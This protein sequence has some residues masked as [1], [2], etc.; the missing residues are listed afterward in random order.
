MVTKQSMYFILM[1]TILFSGCGQKGNPEQDPSGSEENRS[2]VLYLSVEKFDDRLDLWVSDSVRTDI[3]AEGFEWSEGPLWLESEQLLLFSDVPTNT[4]FAWSETD[5][6]TTYLSPSGYTGAAERGGE[7]GSN[8]LLLDNDGGL[9]LC[10]HGDRRIA[11]MIA[12]LSD[13]RPVFETVAGKFDNMR[14]NSPNDLAID[15]SGT[16][17]FTDPP[18]GLEEFISDPT[19][20]TPYQGVYRIDPNGLVTLLTDS[21]TR[22]NGIALSPDE[23]V[24]YIGN[25]DGDKPWWLQYD[26]TAAGLEN[27]KILLDAG[28]VIDGA[29]GPDGMVVAEDGTLLSS[30]HGGIWIIHPDG[31]LLGRILIPQAVSNTTMDPSEKYLFV[32][33]YHQVLRLHLGVPD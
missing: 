31:T 5:G 12:T 33:A 13:P 28:R 20:E 2:N 21:I 9:L 32:T 23:S 29:R 8:G 6:L 22:P 30:G 17:Y 25:S 18:Y 10:Q 3:L 7:M 14:F 4:V 24:L 16:V 15:R 27:G 1:S 11:R 26:L 19:R